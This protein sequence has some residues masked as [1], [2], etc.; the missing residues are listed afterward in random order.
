MQA[1]CVLEI[2]IYLCVSHKTAHAASD[3][4]SFHFIMREFN[5]YHK[6]CSKACVTQDFSIESTAFTLMSGDVLA[7]ETICNFYIEITWTIKS[8]QIQKD[9]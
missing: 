4:F 6:M 1:T 8:N 5:N 7:I 3:D 2:W 9:I